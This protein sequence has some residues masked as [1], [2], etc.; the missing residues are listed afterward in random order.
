MIALGFDLEQYNPDGQPA[1]ITLPISCAVSTLT[2]PAPD[3]IP[4]RDTLAAD[5]YSTAEGGKPDPVMDDLRL[6]MLI[7][8]LCNAA[9]GGIPVVTWHGAAYDLP[10]LAHHSGRHAEMRQVA[11]GSID[12]H[13][14]FMAVKRHRLGLKTAA[15]A[16]GSHKGGDEIADG[17]AA[18]ILWP[19][20]WQA[21]LAYCRQDV[22]ATLDVFEHL[23]AFGDFN[24]I[25]S[26]H[27]VMTFTLPPDLRDPACWTV[28]HLLKNHPWPLPEPWITEPCSPGDAVFDWL[29]PSLWPV[30]L[31]LEQTRRPELEQLP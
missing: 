16:V 13:L 2:A 10:C 15:A 12:L 9:E 27:R 20:Q 30:K 26:K 21:I 11:L 17:G 24:W 31:P 5:W 14:L 18:S 1:S 7:D 4:R 3:F 8:E 28:E 19:D 22:Q 23:R 25:S 6:H 29:R